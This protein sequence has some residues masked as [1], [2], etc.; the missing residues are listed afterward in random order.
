MF[1]SYFA[2]N[3]CRYVFSENLVLSTETIKLSMNVVNKINPYFQAKGRGF[4]LTPN[5]EKTLMDI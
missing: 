2:V 4:G 5:R 3:S 1:L